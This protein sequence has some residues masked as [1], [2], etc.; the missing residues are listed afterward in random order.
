MKNVSSSSD[1]SFRNL[2]E[3]KN[4]LEEFKTG[5]SSENEEVENT[6]ENN[7]G[8]ENVSDEEIV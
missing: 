8:T 4:V 7:S 6:L 1:E 2:T 5:E 3:L